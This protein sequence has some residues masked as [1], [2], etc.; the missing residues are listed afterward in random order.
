[1]LEYKFSVQ[2][3]KPSEIAVADLLSRQV[4]A[5][6]AESEQ[7]EILP[8]A[9]N[10]KEICENYYYFKLSLKNDKY[11]QFTFEFLISFIMNISNVPL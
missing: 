6:W 11:L 7:A 9:L 5:L 10:A 8:I 4:N 2:Y 3:C 1:M